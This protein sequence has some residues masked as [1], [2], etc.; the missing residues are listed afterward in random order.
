[1]LWKRSISCK[2]C[3]VP[4]AKYI[5][6]QSGSSSLPG[7][8]I[9]KISKISGMKDRQESSDEVDIS[10][11]MDVSDWSSRIFF[12][13]QM[14]DHGTG[15]VVSFIQYYFKYVYT[16][17]PLFSQSWLECH[18]GD[19]PLHLLHAMY[20]C[21]LA[22]SVKTAAA[23]KRHYR[24]AVKLIHSDLEVSDPFT[25][26]ALLHLAVFA[27]S[28]KDIPALVSH[29]VVATG[30]AKHMRLYD[31]KPIWQSMDGKMY[32]I[33]NFTLGLWLQCYSIDLNIV[34]LTNLE[35]LIDSEVPGRVMN[36]YRLPANAAKINGLDDSDIKFFL[37]LIAL[38]KRHLRIALDF[39][40]DD[41]R[42]LQTDLNEWYHCLPLAMRFEPGERWKGPLIGT[43]NTLYITLKL[44]ILS[45]DLLNALDRARAFKNNPLVDSVVMRC[46]IYAKQVTE[47]TKSFLSDYIDIENILSNLFKHSIYY[48]AVVHAAIG[49]CVG[50]SMS[51]TL[52]Q[53]NQHALQITLEIHVKAIEALFWGEELSTLLDV[54]RHPAR[55]ISILFALNV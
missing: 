48:A 49:C 53:S 36:D 14:V 34:L 19:V 17:F 44:K 47:I 23:A 33:P 4:G 45:K 24:Y 32:L 46:L 28:V 30:L 39:N 16:L 51:G 54:I 15:A 29:H 12:D 5:S 10:D 25:V 7:A 13:T 40:S 50:D 22:F 26:A 41:N 20:S 27:L 2:D 18:F 42:R 43:L 37:P 3:Q 55:A 21:S 52:S 11:W 1:M 9:S 35:S 6:P 8:K 31:P 38:F